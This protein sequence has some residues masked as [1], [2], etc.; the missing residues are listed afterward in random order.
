MNRQLF[1][2]LARTGGTNMPLYPDMGEVHNLRHAGR[3]GA[4]DFP[5]ELKRNP[6]PR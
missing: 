4:A 1:A 5:P 6:A 3:G 2:E